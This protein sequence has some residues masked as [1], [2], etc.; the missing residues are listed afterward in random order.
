MCLNTP[1][2]IPSDESGNDY[3]V[4]T[5][6]TPP[7][8]RHTQ[9]KTTQGY[10]SKNNMN[11]YQYENIWGF[12]PNLTAGGE[13]GEQARQQGLCHPRQQGDTHC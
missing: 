1:N 5:A 8:I 2:L 12:T 10:H 9:G 3:S 13:G 11:E 7:I 6:S 4:D